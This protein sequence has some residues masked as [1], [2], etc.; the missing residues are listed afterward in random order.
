MEDTSVQFNLGTIDSYGGKLIFQ[1]VVEQDGSAYVNILAFDPNDP[2]NSGVM[3]ALDA[4]AYQ[5]LKQIVE[6]TDNL[7]QR[8]QASNPAIQLRWPF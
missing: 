1:L 6:D 5:R 8:L 3:S 7:V 4:S 2:G